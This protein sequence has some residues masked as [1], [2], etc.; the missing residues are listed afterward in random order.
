MNNHQRNSH[1]FTHL[2]ELDFAIAFNEGCGKEATMSHLLVRSTPPDNLT[3]TWRE[4]LLAFGVAMARQSSIIVLQNDHKQTT[5][6]THVHV[7]LLLL[8]HTHSMTY[9]YT[10]TNYNLPKQIPPCLTL[11]TALQISHYFHYHTFLV[12]HYIVAGNMT[13]E[14]YTHCATTA[15]SIANTTA[16]LK[17]SN[18]P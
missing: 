3:L 8:F 7:H 9:R 4:N 6:P 1:S 15:T 11:P 10:Y 17:H 2:S 5:I 14:Q 18:V 16:G 12:V 13:W